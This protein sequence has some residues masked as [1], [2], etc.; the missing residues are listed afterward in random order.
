[1]IKTICKLFLLWDYDKEEA[2]LN[3]MAATGLA[4]TGV[5]GVRYSFKEGTPGEYTYRM[6]LLEKQPSHAES[7]QYLRFLEGLGVE[8]VASAGRWVYLRKKTQDG[9]FDL[10]SDLDSRIKALRPIRTLLLA[11]MLIALF[12]S[13]YNLAFGLI[14]S[15]RLNIA[16]GVFILVLAAFFG[17]GFVKTQKKIGRLKKEKSIQE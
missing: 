5:S 1:M 8:Q 16:C 15:M 9:P 17:Y 2:W 12:C 10:F 6:Q 4:M 7:V 11:F 14:Y 3:K 13:A